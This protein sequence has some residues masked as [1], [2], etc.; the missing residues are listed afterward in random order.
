MKRLLAVSGNRY[1][2]GHLRLLARMLRRL[3]EMGFALAIH[4]DFHD[5]LTSAGVTLPDGTSRVD[6]IPTAAE[7]AVS[8]GGDGTFLHTAR[9]VGAHAIPVVGI[10]TGHL[11][12]LAHFSTDDIDTLAI[13]LRDKTLRSEPRALLMLTADGH[14]D[15]RYALNEIAILKDETSS[16]IVVNTEIDGSFLAQYRAD[17]L[18]IATA[19]GSTGYNMSAGG[20]LLQPGLDVMLLTPVAP[21]SL[22]LRPLVISGRARVHALTTTRSG[23]YRVS[24]DGSSF[25]LP[26]GSAITVSRAPFGIHVLI[27]PET[28]FAD[29][30]RH[31]LGW[32]SDTP[33]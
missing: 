16:M 2:Q 32:A 15:P 12:Y 5:Y 6:S 22:T 14:P 7:A 30:L 9:W 13:A 3:S 20:P 11:G 18:L 29:T 8:V 21:H 31:K 33:Y 10:N 24:V 27:R 28:T 1:Q 23:Q 26:S 25:I 4:T 19:T 17:G